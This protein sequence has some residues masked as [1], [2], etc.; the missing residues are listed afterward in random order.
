[1][2]RRDG[3]VSRSIHRESHGLVLPGLR[4]QELVCR[5]RRETGARAVWTRLEVSV[6]P[7]LCVLHR[8]RGPCR[9]RTVCDDGHVDGILNRL[10]V[11]SGSVFLLRPFIKAAAAADPPVKARQWPPEDALDVWR[12]V[13]SKAWKSARLRS[14]LSSGSRSVQS[15][16]LHPRSTACRKTSIA[17][18][19]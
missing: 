14:E 17:L 4:C 1:M 11:P 13:L 16:S 12:I 18:S 15:A 2:D 10:L 5:P 9:P 3:V 19:E 7:P 6:H 8:F